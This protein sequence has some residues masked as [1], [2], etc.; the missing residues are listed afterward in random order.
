[1]SPI[2]FGALEI[3]AVV[4]SIQAEYLNPRATPSQSCGISATINDPYDAINDA[5]DG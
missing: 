1:M 5:N 2:L 4:P 3:A